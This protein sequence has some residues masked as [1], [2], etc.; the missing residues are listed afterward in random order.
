MHAGKPAPSPLPSACWEPTFT[1][2]DGKPIPT[3]QCMLASQP[4][5]NLPSACWEAYPSPSPVHAGKA[6]PS[7]SACWEANP[8]PPQ[9]MLASQPPSP[10]PSACWQANPPTQ[11]M[12]VSKAPYPVH[13]E[14]STPPFSQ[15]ILGSQLLPCEQN[16]TQ[17]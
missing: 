6:T 2:H 13:A 17:V 12:L 4:P 16:D 5:S 8:L 14:K 1:V 15:C 10:L 3:S 7:P 11:Y 9:C